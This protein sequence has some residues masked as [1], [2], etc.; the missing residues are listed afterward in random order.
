MNV[1]Q[2]NFICLYN[3][4][5]L[6]LKKKLETEKEILFTERNRCNLLYKSEIIF[7]LIQNEISLEITLLMTTL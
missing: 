1:K 2:I 4:V 7:I 5:I 6:K 3:N